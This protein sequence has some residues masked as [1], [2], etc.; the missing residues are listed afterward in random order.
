MRRV[1][2]TMFL[3][4]VF[5]L[6]AVSAACGDTSD[7]G[8]PGGSG[9]GNA[10]GSGGGPQATPCDK[11]CGRLFEDGCGLRLA[12]ADDLASCVTA[13]NQLPSRMV[14]CISD[15]DCDATRAQA[16]SHTSE[17]DRMCDHV[18]KTCEMAPFTVNGQA[19]DIATCKAQC[20]FQSWS[21]SYIACLTDFDCTAD[22]FNACR[23]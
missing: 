22:G 14:G 15:A 21:D 13:C 3:A 19:I 17:C 5:L 10:G 11:M 20:P 23:N 4:V 2:S 7:D 1:V 12:G 18:Y 8:S 16:C 9:G 6:A